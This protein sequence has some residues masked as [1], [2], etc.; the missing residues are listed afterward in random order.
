MMFNVLLKRMNNLLDDPTI[1]GQ[2]KCP[3][4]TSTTHK[5][6]SSP[7]YKCKGKWTNESLKETMDVV[8]KHVNSLRKAKKLWNITLT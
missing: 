6:E 1:H 4:S 8:K 5:S 2:E 3:T 7:C